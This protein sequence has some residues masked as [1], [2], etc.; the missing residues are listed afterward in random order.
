MNLARRLIIIRTLSGLMCVSALVAAFLSEGIAAQSAALV[1]AALALGAGYLARGLDAGEAAANPV[2]A[3]VFEGGDIARWRIGRDG[4]LLSANDTAQAWFGSDPLANLRKRLDAIGCEEL[5]RLETA[6]ANGLS[7]RAEVLLD[8]TLAPAQSRWLAM[9]VM[10]VAEGG[11]VWR[12]EDVTARRVLTDA[13]RAEREE[14]AQRLDALP[15]G[16]LAVDGAGRIINANAQLAAWLGRDG[17]TLVG[18]P[19]ASICPDDVATLGEDQQRDMTF[20]TANGKPLR[21]A[22]LR[23]NTGD[24]GFLAVL[25]RPSV[26]ARAPA[27]EPLSAATLFEDAPIGILLTDPSGRVEAAN[28]AALRLLGRPLDS[29]AGIAFADLTVPEDRDE[30]GAQLS[31]LVLG[32]AS[33]IRFDLRL[34]G[35]RHLAVTALAGPRRDAEGEVTGLVLHL[36]DTTEQRNLEAQFAGAQKMQAMGQLAGGV[37]HDFNN[38]LT[39][40]IGFCD[41]LLQRHPP[42]DPSFAD[43]MQIKQNANRAANLVRQLLAF[44]RRQ[45]LKPRLVD[46]ATQLTDLT[47]LLRRLLG[48]TIE[49]AIEHGRDL[50]M[51]RVD[52]GQFDQ[53][54]VNLAINARD[55][56]PGG[57]EL[58][59]RTASARFDAPVQRG[60][61]LIPAGDYAAIEVADTGMGISGENIGR[62]FEPFF[63]TKEVGAGTGLGLS[64]VY[65]IL[66]Q[67]EGFIFV[68]SAPGEGAV[69]TILLPR[70]EAV[71][72]ASGGVAT[73][74]GE[75]VPAAEGA[76]SDLTGSATLLLVEDEDA[77]RLFAARALRNKGYRILE[78]RTGE[79][80]IDILHKGE[81]IDLLISDVMM[82]GMDGR[83]LAR[84]V[85]HELPDLRVVLISGYSED[86]ARE[87]LSDDP[88]VHFL[89]KPFS[90]KQLAQTVKDVL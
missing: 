39:A 64:T 36:I 27:L 30:T 20:E 16:L 73:A 12:V 88:A 70:F 83:T 8:A 47:H 69:F 17:E 49:L 33:G 79:Q 85:R 28:R 57:G 10:A 37:A 59:I 26:A 4:L 74:D 35:A 25:Q 11:A 58:T 38:L 45:P 5:A 82:P 80:A 46:P 86:L 89:A 65:G 72:S 24:G 40:M 32:A 19:L 75:T 90:L 15:A 51:V 9:A 60:A 1:L 78:A 55:A 23:N 63:T 13:L 54:I 50:G 56:M 52:P 14:L 81:K 68:N 22:C 3:S 21:L 44:S 34:D 87:G 62:I 66:R 48:E 41:L 7:L 53:V 31:K 2:A 42:G 76:A 84:L 71:A 43:I 6:G 29:L 77:V 67:T 61:E 18:R